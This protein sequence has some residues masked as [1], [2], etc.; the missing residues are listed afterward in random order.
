M[1][2]QLRAARALPLAGVSPP[3]RQVPPHSVVSH[4]VEKKVKNLIL[5]PLSKWENGRLRTSP[6]KLKENVCFQKTN[7]P[8]FY[9]Y[10][11]LLPSSLSARHLPG[12]PL[13]RLSS[14]HS[15][16]DSE[17]SHFTALSGMRNMHTGA[18]E[19]NGKYIL[20]YTFEMMLKDVFVRLL[21]IAFPP[22]N[23]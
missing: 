17:V 23:V 13:T 10:I 15:P 12:Q 11:P 3:P 20:S 18:S 5:Q 19:M 16:W 4:T 14:L 21:R 1:R 8:K 7:I 22:L 9:V 6:G 2:R